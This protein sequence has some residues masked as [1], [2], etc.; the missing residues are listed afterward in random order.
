MFSIIWRKT[1]R[2]HRGAIDI[3]P[4]GTQIRCHRYSGPVQQKE[5]GMNRTER[6]V[7]VSVIIT[8]TAGIFLAGTGTAFAS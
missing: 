6:F 8:A 3:F 4:I 2:S 7:A 5:R 1:L